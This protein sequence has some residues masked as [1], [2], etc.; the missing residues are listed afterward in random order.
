MHNHSLTTPMATTYMYPTGATLPITTVVNSATISSPPASHTRA[1]IA[2]RAKT[3]S[4][5]PVISSAATQSGSQA[6][7]STKNPKS[8]RA[9]STAKSGSKPSS[10]GTANGR[11]AQKSTGTVAAVG[12][13]S[14]RG[15]GGRGKGRGG[16]YDVLTKTGPVPITS[17]DDGLSAFVRKVKWLKPAKDEVCYVKPV[18]NSL[19]LHM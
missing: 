3:K 4:K 19:W 1:K 8:K 16:R 9:T 13:K 10:S 14:S 6:M 17:K 2:A 18:R 15:R 12:A 5:S 7:T 11:Q